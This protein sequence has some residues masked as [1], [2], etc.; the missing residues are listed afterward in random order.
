MVG[1]WGA[2][3]EGQKVLKQAMVAKHAAGEPEAGTSNTSR[4]LRKRTA[5]NANYA[6]HSD[7]APRW[8]EV[9]LAWA[10]AVHRALA[11]L[12]SLQFC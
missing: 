9:T 8:P 1:G 6:Q 5:N 10:R 12:K 4:V 3:N 11:P 7:T 2:G